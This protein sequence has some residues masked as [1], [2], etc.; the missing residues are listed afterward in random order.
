MGIALKE[1]FRRPSRFVSVGGALTMLVVLLIVLGGFLDGLELNSTGPYRAHEG[2]LL[3]FSDGSELLIQR[4]NV[5]TEQAEQLAAADGVAAVGALNQIASTASDR[6]GEIVD[7]VLFGY[8]LPDRRDPLSPGRW[9]R[10][11]RPSPGRSIRRRRRGHA[12]ARRL[13]GAG[14]RVCHRRRSQ[15]GLTDGVALDRALARDR[16]V[17][18]PR[19][20]ATGGH[21]P[22]PGR[23]SERRHRPRGAR[24]PTG[25]DRRDRRGHL[26]RGDPG[27][28]RGPTAVVDLRRHHR[29]HV[30][31]HPDGGGLVLHP[32]HARTGR[33][34]RRAQSAGGQNRRP[35]G[36]HLGPGRRRE[37]GRPGARPRPE[38]GL[39]R[40]PARRPPGPVGAG[41]P[42]PDRGRRVG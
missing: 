20:P 6:N 33:P 4:S 22:S 19:R 21:Q 42:A 27:T 2:R 35:G 12:P 24:T 29:R 31:R 13:I 23:R 9:R 18:K 26:G 11:D 38:R 34:L 7:I 3:V 40:L 5:D 32:D 28:A 15:P 39:R 36:R 10:R 30:R 25:N 1:L 8:D 17:R 14:R 16:R 37:P 41:P